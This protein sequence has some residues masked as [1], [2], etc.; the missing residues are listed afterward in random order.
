MVEAKRKKHVIVVI[1]II[2]IL[3]ISFL[4]ASQFNNAKWLRD[5]EPGSMLVIATYSD[6]PGTGGRELFQTLKSISEEHEITEANS[7]NGTWNTNKLLLPGFKYRRIIRITFSP[8]KD[9]NVVEL[10]QYLNQTVES[11]K[12]ERN[13][14][15]NIEANLI[16][17]ELHNI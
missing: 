8:K 12:K 13:I 1:S 10:E 11:F 9:V 5:P 2:L 7:V 6:I 17:N 16:Y 3:V 14:D 15:S 4:A